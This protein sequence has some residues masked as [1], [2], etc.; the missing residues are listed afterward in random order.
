MFHQLV[1]CLEVTQAKTEL[2]PIP[3]NAIMPNRGLASEMKGREER[4]AGGR[5]GGQEE[6]EGG[7]GGKWRE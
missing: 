3:R 2:S 1:H 7:K 6:R 4:R 5:E